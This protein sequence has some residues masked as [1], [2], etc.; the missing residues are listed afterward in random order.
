MFTI[1]EYYYFQICLLEQVL[2]DQLPEW[3][4]LT[5]ATH[6]LSWNKSYLRWVQKP[7]PRLTLQ[8]SALKVGNFW[9]N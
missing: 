8:D 3:Q 7:T 4:S 6:D 9:I 5:L 1:Q 2:V